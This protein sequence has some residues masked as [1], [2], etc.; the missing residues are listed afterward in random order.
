M[1]EKPRSS[2]LGRSG[3]R[4]LAVALILPFACVLTVPP[5]S[6]EQE[7]GPVVPHDSFPAD[8]SLCHVG[9]GWREIK[10]D[11]S[12]DHAKQTG[13]PLFGAHKKAE[14]LLCH[15]DRGPV[16]VFAKRGCAGCHEDT[17]KGQLGRDCRECHQENTWV[18]VEQIARHARTRFPL[19]GAH[20]AV[21]C[22]RCHPGA[23]V[24]N[25]KR[26]T[27]DCA[28]CHQADLARATSPNHLANGWIEDCQMCH[29]PVS[30][31]GALFQH[32]S[33]AL[34]GAHRA[35]SCSGCHP[36]ERF[37]GTPR[38][39]SGC[40]LN[41][42]RA[43]TS[44]DHV[45]GGFS[46][47]CESCHQ[48][49]IWRGA[50]TFNHSRFFALTGKHRTARCDGCHSGGRFKGTPRSCV[51]CHLADYNLTTDPNHK[52]RGFSTSCEQCHQTASWRGAT[53]VDHNRF[54]PLTGRHKLASC[55]S[56]HPDGRFKG[57]PRTCVGCHL[58]NFNEAKNPDHRL[59]GFPTTCESCHAT[60][61]WRPSSFDHDRFFPLLGRHKMARCSECHLNGRFKG[62]P[63]SCVGCHLDDYSKTTDPNHNLA[64]FP[65]TCESCHGNSAWK[66]ANFDHSRFFTLTGK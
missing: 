46:T 16:A 47:D 12:F 52:T 31:K 27:V 10:E 22:F 21:A 2:S 9:S 14:C 45:R 1:N 7:N 37:K 26:A 53:M 15:N 65:T 60:S 59:A 24:G 57:S 58:E 61:A 39:C 38:D 63:R 54:F 30:F 44:P 28:V 17:H 55:A 33:F 11:F 19:V 3:L 51:G 25:F 34:I 43:T 4:V 64:G 18:P 56:C 13:V 42:F 50:T 8:C 32:T 5:E 40:H 23:Q 29:R 66:P 48:P 62:T 20:V 41:D 49:T 6:W 36:G 35:A